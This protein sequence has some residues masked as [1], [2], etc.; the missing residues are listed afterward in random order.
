MKK[1]W[2]DK[3][4]IYMDSIDRITSGFKSAEAQSKRDR[5]FSSDLHRIRASNQALKLASDRRKGLKPPQ[6]NKIC[7]TKPELAVEA[8]LRSCNINYQ[9]QCPIGPYQFDFF[10]KDYGLLI[11]VQ[12]EYWHSLPNNIRNDIAKATYVSRNTQ[13]KLHYINEINTAM[14]S[15][16]TKIIKELTGQSVKVVDFDFTDLIIKNVEPNIAMTFMKSHHYLPRFRKTTRATHGVFL[17]NELIAIMIYGLPSYNVSHKFGLKLRQVL[18]LSRFVINP[19]FQKKNLASWTLSRSIKL[20]KK[21]NLNVNMIISFADPHFGHTG[22]IYKAAGWEYDGET[23]PSY[24]YIDNNNNIFHKKTLWDHAKK[25]RMSE[26]DYALKHS[27]LR[28][29][30]EP[31]KKFIKWLKKLVTIDKPKPTGELVKAM[32]KCG[33]T[34]TLKKKNYKRAFKKYGEYVCHSCS[35]K[36]KWLDNNYREK[37]K[38]GRKTGCTIADITQAVCDNCNTTKSIKKNAYRNN[39]NKHG[40][41]LCHSCALKKWHKNRIK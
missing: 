1:R 20:I 10:L 3:P 28:I 12:G 4:H 38:L 18:D 13:F 37:N 6:N 5:Y 11:E 14:Q 31:K 16:I 9:K 23:R 33:F 30:T 8:V 25:N 32:C 41:Y 34:N 35:L 27:F 19:K 36:K 24:Y 40:A 7:D 21:S 39:I 17:N 26:E 2:Q 22:S 29:N 15:G